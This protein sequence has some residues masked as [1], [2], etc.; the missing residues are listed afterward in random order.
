M[1]IRDRAYI[2]SWGINIEKISKIAVLNANY[3]L[4]LLKEDFDVPYDRRCAHEFVISAKKFGEKSTINIAK[5]IIDYGFHAPTIY[6]PLIVKEALM[7]EPTETES[8]ET[9]DEYAKVLKTIIKELKE[10]PE[11]VK[12]AP[13]TTP[14]RLDEVKAARQ[15]NLRWIPKES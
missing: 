10:E 1:C 7:I 3:L 6:F 5:R 9:L 2:K 11:L 14:G 8:K 13:Y 15:L 12:N 4:C